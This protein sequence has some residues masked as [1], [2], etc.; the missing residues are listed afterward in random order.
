MA[1]CKVVNKYTVGLFFITT[2]THTYTHTLVTSHGRT[3]EGEIND[4]ARCG[5]WQLNR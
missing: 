1:N 4:E 3:A 5:R 2:H